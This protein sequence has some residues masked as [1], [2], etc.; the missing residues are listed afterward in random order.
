MLSNKGDVGFM[1]KAARRGILRQ[2]ARKD[3]AEDAQSRVL[4][5]CSWDADP[6][7]AVVDKRAPCTDAFLH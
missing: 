5:G 4:E 6:K 2:G 1:V 7:E 3:M